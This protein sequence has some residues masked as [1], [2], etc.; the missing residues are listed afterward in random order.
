MQTQVT[1]GEALSSGGRFRVEGLFEMSDREIDRRKAGWFAR[2]KCV[3]AQRALRVRRATNA[4][5]F[6]NHPATTGDL[7]GIRQCRQIEL[8][9]LRRRLQQR[10]FPSVEAQ[11]PGFSQV[12]IYIL[13]GNA[14]EETIYIGEADPVGDRL[15]NSRL[16]QGRLGVWG[17]YFFDR[18]HKIG[19]TE[20]QY[21]ELAAGCPGQEA[22][23][24]HSAEQE[25]LH[26][27]DDGPRCEGHSPGAPRRH[28]DPADAWHQRFHP[29]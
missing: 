14:A 13:V 7:E 9:G 6:A 8:V 12:G 21:P 5:V 11:E 23:P 2:F 28:V 20:V 29:A 16:E 15:K 3:T 19:K 24:G 4:A 27:S 1:G 22:R 25:Q 17:V 18:N 26:G 10:A